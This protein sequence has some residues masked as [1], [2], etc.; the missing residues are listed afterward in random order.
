MT[1]KGRFGFGG[2]TTS[3]NGHDGT[4]VGYPSV[5]VTANVGLSIMTYEQ[6]YKDYRYHYLLKPIA[7]WIVSIFDEYQEYGKGGIRLQPMTK[8]AREEKEKIEA[9]LKATLN[10]DERA[11]LERQLKKLIL[12]FAEPNALVYAFLYQYGKPKS[13]YSDVASQIAEF[14]KEELWQDGLILSGVDRDGFS[15]D[16]QTRWVLGS[17]SI[18][19]FMRIFDLQ[20]PDDFAKYLRRTENTFKAKHDGYTLLDLADQTIA[21]V[22]ERSRIE[23]T[24]HAIRIG[25]PEVTSEWVGVL[26]L[27]IEYFK[28][29]GKADFVTE[30]NTKRQFYT[31]ELT[32]LKGDR[33]SLPQSTGRGE[34]SGFH[35]YTAL[36]DDA[37]A[38]I[39]QYYI[40]VVA[41]DNALTPKVV[42]TDAFTQELPSLK[43]P[44]VQLTE[45]EI[46]RGRVEVVEDGKDRK[47]YY[48]K[49]RDDLFEKRELRKKKTKR[50]EKESADLARLE[51]KHKGWELEWVDPTNG[52]E[53]ILIDPDHKKLHIAL[54]SSSEEIKEH[55]DIIKYNYQ[56]A[57]RTRMAFVGDPNTEFYKG[58]VVLNYKDG[59]PIFENNYKIHN[60]IK[61]EE[62]LKIIA[63]MTKEEQKAINKKRYSNFKITLN[64][65]GTPREVIATLLFPI[66]KKIYDVQQNP[67]TG[68]YEISVYQKGMRRYLI[69]HNEIIIPAYHEKGFSLITVGDISG[70]E[71]VLS[72]IKGDTNNFWTEILKF[73]LGSKQFNEIDKIKK[74]D[75]LTE[76]MKAAI[77]GGLNA[78]KD[79]PKFYID[80][81][82]N[83]EL[84]EGSEASKELNALKKKGIFVEENGILSV[85]QGLSYAEK[86][87][88]KWFNIAILKQ[89]YPRILSESHK[90]DPNGEPTMIEVRTEKY[91]YTPKGGYYPQK[92]VLKTPVE[93]KEGARLYRGLIQHAQQLLEQPRIQTGKTFTY[94]FDFDKESSRKFA[95]DFVLGTISLD[96]LD[97]VGNQ[98]KSVDEKSITTRKHNP[99][100]L[101]K[102]SVVFDNGQEAIV[103]EALTRDR[104]FN[105]DL[106]K[107][108]LKRLTNPVQEKLRFTDST[109]VKE[110]DR[111]MSVYEYRTNVTRKDHAMGKQS[112]ERDNAYFG[113][114]FAKFYKD[115]FEQATGKVIEFN[116]KAIPLYSP[117]FHFGRIPYKTL[118]YSVD[119]EDLVITLETLSYDPLTRKLVM[120]ETDHRDNDEQRVL[121]FG[122]NF[123]KPIEIH[124]Q[125]KAGYVFSTFLQHNRTETDTQGV[126]FDGVRPGEKPTVVLSTSKTNYDPKTQQTRVQID[127]WDRYLGK[128]DPNNDLIETAVRQV[129]RIGILIK[130]NI[131]KQGSTVRSVLPVYDRGG[132]EINRYDFNHD[133]LV[134]RNGQKVDGKVTIGAKNKTKKSV[135]YFN[136]GLGNIE[137]LTRKGKPLNAGN[138]DKV[139]GYYV[140]EPFALSNVPD[141]LR[142]VSDGDLLKV[143][144]RNREDEFSRGT[145]INRHADRGL[146]YIEKSADERDVFEF[147][148]RTKQKESPVYQTTLQGQLGEQIATIVLKEDIALSAKIENQSVSVEG[149][150]VERRDYP[151]RL[152][153]RVMA[154]DSKHGKVVFNF[155]YNP[156][157]L[158]GSRMIVDGTVL[159]GDQDKFEKRPLYYYVAT[160]TGYVL[161]TRNGK[162]LTDQNKND[163]VGIASRTNDVLEG[164]PND[165]PR[166]MIS[167]FQEPDRFII[168]QTRDHL[169][170]FEQ[171]F[172]VD[173]LNE[174]VRARIRRI[175]EEPNYYLIQFIINPYNELS[176]TE[177]KLKTYIAKKQGNTYDI[178]QRFIRSYALTQSLTFDGLVKDLFEQTSPYTEIIESIRSGEITSLNDV[179]ARI[180]INSQQATDVVKTLKQIGQQNTGTFD[181]I[182]S[183]IIT[184]LVEVSPISFREKYI[185]RKLRQS[186][187]EVVEKLT[188]HNNRTA[189]ENTVDTQLTF[190][191]SKEVREG[192]GARFFYRIKEDSLTRVVIFVSSDL[193]PNTAINIEFVGQNPVK[194]YEYTNQG[195]VFRLITT[196]EEKKPERSL[197]DSGFAPEL[198]S[199]L[200]AEKSLDDL[201]RQDTVSEIEK[202]LL[203]NPDGHGKFQ[204]SILFQK[205]LIGGRDP[206]FRDLLRQEMGGTGIPRYIFDLNRPFGIS[207]GEVAVV[208]NEDRIVRRTRFVKKD[209][210]EY[211]Y[212]VTYEFRQGQHLIHSPLMNFLGLSRDII[213]RYNYR[214]G[215]MTQHY[216]SEGWK[217]YSR[218]GLPLRVT[219]VNGDDEAII[220]VFETRVMHLGEGLDR[221]DL[222]LSEE[223]MLT[224]TTH[225]GPANRLYGNGD[226]LVIEDQSIIPGF[227]DDSPFNVNPLIDFLKKVKNSGPGIIYSKALAQQLT[228]NPNYRAIIDIIK[229]EGHLI[230]LN[231]P[232]E[233]IQNQDDFFSR[234]K[235]VS[236]KWINGQIGFSEAVQK[237]THTPEAKNNEIPIYSEP[238]RV[239][240]NYWIAIA[241]VFFLVLALSAS[242]GYRIS[243]F[244]NS[245]RSNANIM[246][247]GKLF[248]IIDNKDKK[249]ARKLKNLITLNGLIIPGDKIEEEQKVNY[250][251]SLLRSSRFTVEEIK[252]IISLMKK[253]K[254]KFEDENV[255]PRSINAPIFNEEG[256]HDQQIQQAAKAGYAEA[257]AIDLMRPYLTED[258]FNSVVEKAKSRKG[259]AVW[260]LLRNI[261]QA[262]FHS[263]V[264]KQIQEGTLS[265]EELDTFPLTPETRFI[266]YLVINNIFTLEQLTQFA[267]ER[268][269][270]TL[271]SF[272]NDFIQGEIVAPVFDDI[273]EK[274]YKDVIQAE[275][276]AEIFKTVSNEMIATILRTPFIL[277]G[278]KDRQDKSIAE[279]SLVHKPYPHGQKIEAVSLQELVLHRFVMVNISQTNKDGATDYR[280]LGPIGAITSLSIY[281]VRHIIKQ[282]ESGYSVDQVQEYIH[283]FSTTFISMQYMGNVLYDAFVNRPLDK[284]YEFTI[285]DIVSEMDLYDLFERLQDRGMTFE[286][287]LIKNG[288][289][290]DKFEKD[291]KRIVSEFKDKYT[292]INNLTAVEEILNAGH[293]YLKKTRFLDEE[294]VNMFAEESPEVQ[295]AVESFR[296]TN[297]NEMADHLLHMVREGLVR[298]GPLVGLLATVYTDNVGGTKR[299]FILL[300]NKYR[301]HNKPKQRTISLVYGIGALSKFGKTKDSSLPLPGQ[302]L[303]TRDVVDEKVRS[304]GLRNFEVLSLPES[305]KADRQAGKKTGMRHLLYYRMMKMLVS[306]EKFWEIKHIRLAKTVI[307][308]LIFV[309]VLISILTN[310]LALGTIIISMALM[311]T[312]VLF[313]WSYNGIREKIFWASIFTT[314]SLF[315]NGLLVHVLFN[316]FGTINFDSVGFWITAGLLVLSFVPTLVSFYHVHIFVVSHI[317]RNTDRFSRVARSHT[318]IL[319]M[320]RLWTKWP[321]LFAKWY[322]E[323]NHIELH[324]M[325]LLPAQT[326]QESL[327]NLVK[328]LS[329]KGLLDPEETRLWLLALGEKGGKFVK[330]KDAEAF[331]KLRLAFE[332][333]SLQKPIVDPFMTL[334]PVTTINQSS[335]ETFVYTLE[336]TILPGSFNDNPEWKEKVLT[337]LVNRILRTTEDKQLLKRKFDAIRLLAKSVDTDEAVELLSGNELGA[338]SEKEKEYARELIRKMKFK[339]IKGRLLGY[340]ARVHEHTWESNILQ[341][342]KE[343]GEHAIFNELLEV[344]EF[345]DFAEIL[346]ERND[347]T[348]EMIRGISEFISLWLSEIRPTNISSIESQEKV[349]AEY[350]L[351][352]AFEEGDIDYV[353][354]IRDYTMKGRFLKEEYRELVI[355]TAED[356]TKSENIFVE[357]YPYY[358]ELVETKINHIFQDI[359]MWNQVIIS[360]TG[361]SLTPLDSF[362][363]SLRD[364]VNE[365][366]QLLA[367]YL[368]NEDLIAKDS[369]RN[370]QL[371]DDIKKA[372]VMVE[373]GERV[374]ENN[375]VKDYKTQ[376]FEQWAYNFIQFREANLQTIIPLLKVINDIELNEHFDRTAQIAYSRLVTERAGVTLSLRTGEDRVIPNKKNV[377]LAMNLYRMASNLINLDAHVR[378]YPGQEYGVL[379]WIAFQ[380]SKNIS[381]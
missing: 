47:T 246:S 171:G 144:F 46:I 255:D 51:A 43:R 145:I 337:K 147:L 305:A 186:L 325:P 130:E 215:I 230:K 64:I 173:T 61:L 299:E 50:T 282:I 327:E 19:E 193:K 148:W 178:V 170:R 98:V 270:R 261:V 165:L 87:D 259:S 314:T 277:D 122:P 207:S 116:L 109:G 216:T 308:S 224:D 238:A 223:K 1:Q 106:A 358:Q 184:V 89:H 176:K 321:R 96:G 208:P 40:S 341:L 29:H 189:I 377:A 15:A 338:F 161:L 300:S 266:R 285:H 378:I 181:D 226:L 86:E 156:K 214:T 236:V 8:A 254:L 204:N 256:N 34:D 332:S 331:E 271:K 360:P 267:Q 78:I 191:K 123:E 275:A 139:V 381:H 212:L 99:Y 48:K 244:I 134:L 127:K 82:Q 151:T 343:F 117:R 5:A 231:G 84:S 310:Y 376:S 370:R 138:K 167:A 12:K 289:N 347:I 237:I 66:D 234:L 21:D 365:S 206:L 160:D 60:S 104:K 26:R 217:L 62:I 45:E 180:A 250:I 225:Y 194:A 101:P 380:A 221:A 349:T 239:V 367:T 232:S 306:L 28:R 293:E 108:L 309:G 296:S 25:F 240:L 20:T 276:L 258:E 56:D 242:I 243:R 185:T 187:I 304:Q 142:N 2:F 121:V 137:L 153:R 352:A 288:T 52:Q 200:K 155:F 157:K 113:R 55:T 41:G 245:L 303:L 315:V 30:F 213:L 74:S 119:T 294:I 57:V 166:E 228:G 94:D 16:A 241:F 135:Y 107:A 281:L 132:V 318:G 373:L 348:P 297:E 199:K 91:A 248:R 67:N 22:S 93:S 269:N 192:D 83:I 177:P 97:P 92:F 379:H 100:G 260:V 274:A 58:G 53:F 105:E 79:D 38:S 209:S 75:Q 183:G 80:N 280:S 7:D 218:D 201:L 375:A 364:K 150:I 344:N 159:I 291:I 154:I 235:N 13:R 118:I 278:L 70:W 85:K 9:Q 146:G 219:G 111:D 27:S 71:A 333:L 36:G 44:E 369:L 210:D 3:H 10:L 11:S 205:R 262:R 371:G 6:R 169:D 126:S 59:N 284:D 141:N 42:E 313:G 229:R 252:T 68:K 158:F 211:V 355:K 342:R 361:I 24:N 65:D 356:R 197:T 265:I 374:L 247:L 39:A 354:A 312:P 103:P 163:I 33:I 286:D 195:V 298:E 335:G 272:V 283:K 317:I 168:A 174:Q 152:L 202:Y 319:A 81:I 140:Q 253:G 131:V 264:L 136:G 222:M 359:I 49:L 316:K 257:M 292:L 14:A 164:L 326:V 149:K 17:G 162:P 115:K 133:H 69:T 302:A 220:S 114:I 351:R 175:P 179:I 328:Q 362:V 23:G 287:V 37:L 290:F 366:R 76:E 125:N 190:I 196:P 350:H 35:Y 88:I 95:A 323:L 368:N 339:K 124:V 322:K 334:M 112:Y 77:V 172:L 18:E 372:R 336:N 346:F 263:N 90:K 330:P 279:L 203:F 251:S 301:K 4:N 120:K 307:F 357:G 182:A 233:Y 363:S 31:N 340:L 188:D 295:M 268:S 198:I 345:T 227:I 143:E 128:S 129:S 110:T 72:V 54:I 320:F 273:F 63:K 329:R 102:G 32:R 324:H 353:Q 249:L 73:K 311:V